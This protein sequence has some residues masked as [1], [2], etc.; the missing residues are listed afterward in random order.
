MTKAR[1]KAK[2]G[3]ETVMSREK[4]V[5]TSVRFPES[6]WKAGRIRAI[7]EGRDF[8]E[9]VSEALRRYLGKGGR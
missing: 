1:K 2:K 9:I 3:K 4:Q 7:E 5:K 6:L 8:Q